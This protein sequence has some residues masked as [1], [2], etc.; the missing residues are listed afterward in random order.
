[1]HWLLSAELPE[2]LRDKLR[3]NP[4]DPEAL[5]AASRF[6]QSNPDMLGAAAK[7]MSEMTPGKAPAVAVHSAA[8]LGFSA[9]RSAEH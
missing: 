1:M 4:Y 2:D 7:M 3:R 8:S 6:M 9:A 5:A